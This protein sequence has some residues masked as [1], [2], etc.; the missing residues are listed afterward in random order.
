M[1]RELI[2][3][4]LKDAMG[5]HMPTVGMV[6]VSSA[7]DNRMRACGIMNENEYFIRINSDSS[8]MKELIE[9][10]IIP[11]TWFF[12]EH[13]PYSYVLKY[14]FEQDPDYITKI[15]SMPCSTGEEPYSISM[16]L[17]NNH[18]HPKRYKIDAVDIARLNI[19]KAKAGKYRR[20]SF[21]SDDKSFIKDYF[22]EKDELFHI[23]DKVKK[24]VNFH[25]ENVLAQ[26][27]S[28]SNNQ[29]DVIFCRN[30]LIYFDNDT[31]KKMFSIIQK[32]LLPNGLLVLG[33]AETVQHSNGEFVFAL[34]SSS[35]AYVKKDNLSKSRQHKQN[36][37]KQFF[38]KRHSKSRPLNKNPRSFSAN[39][40]QATQN[41]GRKTPNENLEVAFELANKGK[42][43][44]SLEICNSHI[45]DNPES[46]RAYYLLGLIQDTQGESNKA[47]ECFR[48]AVYL[49]PENL[50][51]IIH[52]SL[53]AKKN[54]NDDEAEK[55]KLRAQRVK[56]RQA[57]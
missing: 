15:L 1:S 14:I 9:T 40:T 43:K 18:V 33:Q 25:C 4:K 19:G 45:K 31:Q 30:L 38:K 37:Q 49:D 17:M 7:I 28:L 57:G 22:T 3:E 29:Y 13:Q 34:G 26:E 44:K 16:M 36:S 55:L 51:A 8:E 6:T 10:I 53:L 12:R 50:E 39:K 41:V 24:Q 46:S 32:M 35:H 23:A 5:L 56:E 27:F 48:K 2:A 42:L 47:Y 21:R 52:L 54:G 11:E 20:N